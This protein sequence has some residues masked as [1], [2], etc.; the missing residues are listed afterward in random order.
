M[1]ET[2]PI[3]NE[4]YV[5]FTTYTRDGRAKSGPVWIADLGDG[6][7]GFTTASSSYKVKRLGNDPRCTLQP[8]D[9]RGNLVD[10]SEPVSGTAVA[11]VENFPVVKP[12]V[13]SKY[14][15][16]YRMIDLVGKGAKLIGRGSGTDT[17]VVITLDA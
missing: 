2:H 1:A 10:G 15:M 12:K 13:L 16:Q 9:S 8:C 11:S 14:G 4:R 5:S 17:G 7:V 6:T 3:A